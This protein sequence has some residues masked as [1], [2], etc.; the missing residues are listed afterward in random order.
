MGSRPEFLGLA[1]GDW[2]TLLAYYGFNVQRIPATFA[3]GIATFS[4]VGGGIYSY[5]AGAVTIQDAVTG[6]TYTNT[7][8]LSIGAGSLSVPTIVTCPFQAQTAGAASSANAG[9]VSAIVT[10]MTGVSVTNAL[11]FVG[12]DAQSDSSLIAACQA[13]LGTLSPGGPVQAYQYAVDTALNAGNPVNVNRRNVQTNPLTGTVNV[14]CASPAGP[15]ASSDLAAI[16]A[17]I[18]AVAVPQA[19]TFNVVSASPVTYA[20]TITI[21]AQGLAGVDGPTIAANALSAVTAY[22]EAY[23][24][25]G[26]SKGAVSG[27][28]GSGVAGAIEAVSAA[29]FAVDGCADLA[30]TTSQVAANGI[31][32]A[33]IT[34]NVVT[35]R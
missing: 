26:L 28:W 14:I 3:G 33:S 29:I 2:L 31:T 10:T 23:P 19:V 12:T 25:G 4:N 32:A 30:L 21:W 8:P 18:V 27:L 9:D 24:I 5:V 1:S 6:K 7:A 22:L 20:P 15:V 17:N 11:P 16:V 35:A 34:V 13:K